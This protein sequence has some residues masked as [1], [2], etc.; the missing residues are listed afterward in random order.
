MFKKTL[1]TILFLSALS[2]FAQEKTDSIK[3]VLD[4]LVQA[5]VRCIFEGKAKEFLQFYSKDY[6]DLGGGKNA[7][8]SVDF[9]VWEAKLERFIASDH[10]KKVE[11]KPIEYSVDFENKEIFSYSEAVEEFGGMEK[12][13]FS[14]SE[15]DYF[16]R[17]PPTKDSPVFDGWV[18]VFRL[19]EGVWKVVAGD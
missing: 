3:V 10:F 14:L 19:E 4:S 17:Y 13:G 12:F 2:V 9:E 11:G 18:G 16:F 7:D 15:G 8:G 1:F 5:Q 6:T